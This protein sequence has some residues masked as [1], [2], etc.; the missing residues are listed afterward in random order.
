MNFK[1]TW[2][3]NHGKKCHWHCTQAEIGRKRASGAACMAR[4]V[5][6]DHCEFEIGLKRSIGPRGN[7][8]KGLTTMH[9]TLT[10]ARKSSAD[11]RP[12]AV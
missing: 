10:L 1:R 12:I 9:H 11:R 7:S 4:N 6:N 2:N 3:E 5:I 8:S